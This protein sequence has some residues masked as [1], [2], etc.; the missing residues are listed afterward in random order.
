MLG[1]GRTNKKKMF[2]V[3][4]EALMDRVDRAATGE[5]LASG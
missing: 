4:R 2:W 5:A 3:D 1:T